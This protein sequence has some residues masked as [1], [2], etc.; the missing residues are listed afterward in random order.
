MDEFIIK[1][2]RWKSSS[3]EDELLLSPQVDG[4]IIKVHRWTSSSYEDDLLLKWTDSLLK[5][6]GGRVHPM[7]MG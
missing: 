3:Y 5:S 6:I 2:H 1:V 7:R 4:F